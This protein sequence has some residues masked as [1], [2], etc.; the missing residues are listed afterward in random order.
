VTAI[1]NG[2]DPDDFGGP[3][4]LRERDRFVVAHVGSLFGTRN[5]MALWQAL[6]RFAQRQSRRSLEIR[7]VGRVSE[8]AALAAAAHGLSVERTGYVSHA[9]AI[10]EM[11]SA[12]LLILSSEDQSVSE[13]HIPGKLFEYLASGTPVLGIGDPHGDAAA[14]LEST[15]GGRMFDRG[16]VGGILDFVELLFRG[17]KEGAKG[18]GAR[19][20]A[21]A[22]FS[23]R[24]QAGDLAKLVR[25]LVVSSRA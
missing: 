15:G 13:G 17:W 7:L 18:A 11:R 5:P 21:V 2:Y 22:P 9:M 6:D 8:D 3:P 12:D 4:P 1:Y 14:I 23:R 16:D 10:S 25:N 24:R 20:E 19:P